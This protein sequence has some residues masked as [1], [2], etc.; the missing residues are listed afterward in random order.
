M[1]TT[2]LTMAQALVKFLD[3]QYVEIDGVQSKFVAGVFTIFGHGNVLGLGQALEQDSGE[4]VVH[5]GRNEQGMCHAA[6]GF[7]KQHLRRKIYACTSSVGPGAANMITAAATASAN[8]IPL[9]LL[10][11]DVYASRQPD[12]VLQQIEQFHDLS[13]STNDAFKAVSKYWDRINRPEQL[14]SAALNAMRVLTDPADTGAVTLSLPQDVQAEA[15]DYPDSFLQKRVHRIDRRPP[16]QAM[17]GDALALLSGKRKPLLICGGGVR[18]SGAA[19]ALQAF[20]ERFGIPFAETQAGKS[21]IVSAHPL[22]MGGIGETGTIAAN[23]LAKEADL[24]IGVGTRYSD[25]TTASKWL[26]Q[27]PDVQFLNLNVGAFDVQKLDGVQVLADAQVAL[28]ALTEQLESRDYRAAWGDAPRAARAELDA[29]V[30]RVYAVEYQP[31]G[32]V[33]EI[34]DHMDPAVLRD[35]IELTGSC[36]TQSRV[37]GILN[38][39]LP[40]DAVI[41]AAAGSL[42]GDLQRAWRSTGVDTYHVEYGY[43]CMGYEVNA[44]LG[45]KLAQ[46]QREVFALVGDGSYMMLHS[47][48]ATSIQERRKINIVLLDNMTFGCINNLQMEHGMNSFGTE[49]RFRNEETGQLDG[50]FVPVDFAMSAAAYGCKTYKVSTAEQLHE[51][52]ADAQRQTVSTLI[53]IKVLPKTMIHKYLSWWRVGVAEVSTTGTTAQVYEKLNQQLAKARQY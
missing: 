44:A 18:Y 28:Q 48:L 49:F 51:A 2:R 15:W 43:S 47:E 50:D 37:L 31:E 8:R 33:P 23:R 20:A 46:P 26:F 36:L 9:L 35:F 40:A 45:V 1:S 4:L 42:P 34:N 21:A 6:I 7:A 12:P 38:Q 5:Q 25:F 39:N 53:D 29:E 30:D 32:F 14:M 17:L 16:S 24:I 3:N 10:P 22:N 52:L 19:Q 13:I 27:N 41:V 11:G